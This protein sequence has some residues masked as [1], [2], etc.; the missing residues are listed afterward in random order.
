MERTSTGPRTPDP[1]FDPVR[2]LPGHGGPIDWSRVSSFFE[3]GKFTVKVNG[4]VAIGAEA[5]TVDAL[6]DELKAG[7]RLDFGTYQDVLVTAPAGAAA[8]AVSIVV[9]ALSGPIPAGAVLNFSGAGEFAVT[10]AAVAAGAVA[11][12]VEALDAAIEAA[13]TATFEGGDINAVVIEDAIVGATALVVEA[14]QFPIADNAEATVK[15]RNAALG[16]RLPKGLVIAK[17][18]A[19]LLIPRRDA[20]AET[21][22]GFLVSD[23]DERSASDSKSGYGIII[24]GTAIYENLCPDADAATGDLPAAYKTELNTNTLGFVYYDYEDTRIV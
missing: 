5:V 12:P 21:A 3:Q 14:T 2:M 6:E 17:T 23:A 1:F 7:T 15:R 16:R 13:D 24:G 19:G 18:A 8:A 11:I 20:A 4:A 9:S 22:V 10:T